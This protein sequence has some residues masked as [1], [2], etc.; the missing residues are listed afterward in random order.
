MCFVVVIHLFSY[1]G[2]SLCICSTQYLQNTK[3]ATDNIIQYAKDL[4][5]Y[6]PPPSE[7]KHRAT[8]SNIIIRSV[9]PPGPGL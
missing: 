6:I 8:H 5:S 9:V 4:E 3:T 1:S 7:T 2:Y